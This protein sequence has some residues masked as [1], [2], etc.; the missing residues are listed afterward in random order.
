VTVIINPT[1]SSADGATGVSSTL[2]SY[3]EPEVLTA[4][5][6]IFDDAWEQITAAGTVTAKEADKRRTD[7]AK[8]IV[9]AHRSGM[10][11]EEIKGAVLGLIISNAADA[12]VEE[13]VA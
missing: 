2:K 11:P 4:L 12:G 1:A 6:A 5:Q 7:L 8:M 10:P 3:F 13:S 9:F